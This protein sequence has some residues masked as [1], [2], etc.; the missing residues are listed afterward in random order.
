MTIHMTTTAAITDR[1]TAIALFEAW[2][3]VNP[4]APYQLK[5]EDENPRRMYES[6]R[7]DAASRGFAAGLAAS[8]VGSIQSQFEAWAGNKS[9]HAWPFSLEPTKY[10]NYRLYHSD[11]TQHAYEGFLAAYEQRLQPVAPA[12][13][14]TTD[15][16][17]VLRSAL[18]AERARNAQLTEALA[19]FERLKHPELLYTALQAGFPTRLP[20]RMFRHLANC[21]DDTLLPAQ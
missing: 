10:F 15:D 4:W 18:A 1:N 21:A 11:A 7:T 2:A 17:A 14:A 13:V 12:A 20:E 8:G 16:V 3:L 9:L 19:Q 5:R 6:E